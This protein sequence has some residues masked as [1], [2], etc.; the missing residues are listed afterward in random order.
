[1]AA[2]LQSI[3]LVNAAGLLNASAGFSFSESPGCPARSA[4][5]FAMDYSPAR[6]GSSPAPAADWG[7]APRMS[8]RAGCAR[9]AGRAQAR[10][11]RSGRAR[12]RGRGRTGAL[13]RLRHP[14]G[15]ACARGRARGDRRF[16]PVRFPRQQCGRTVRLAAREHFRERFRCCRAYQSHRRLPDGARDLCAMDEAARR[17][18]RE[19]DRRHVERNARHGPFRRRRAPACSN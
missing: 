19:H 5:F 3:C 11:A 10:Q 17:R 7:A 15:G 8:S 9:R 18:D 2:G 1:M 14:R 16:R 6:P 12:D 13:L 4:R